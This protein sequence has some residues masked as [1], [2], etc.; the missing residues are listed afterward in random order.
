MNEYREKILK[1]ILEYEKRFDPVDDFEVTDAIG[2]LY[3]LIRA[4][5][6]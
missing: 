4:I 1:T 6:M 5:E 3:E 2:Y